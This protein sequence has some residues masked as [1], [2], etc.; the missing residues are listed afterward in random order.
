MI[1]EDGNLRVEKFANLVGSFGNNAYLVSDEVSREA[2]IVDAPAGS[3]VVLAAV[4][5]GGYVVKAVLLTHSHRDHWMGYEDVKAGTRAPFL[6]HEAERGVLGDR[7]DA[8]VS[9]RQDISVGEFAVHAIHTPGHTPGSTC[10]LVNGIVFSGDTLFP[11]GPGKTQTPS[12]LLQTIESI[13]ARLFVLPDET[14]VLPGHGDDTT[15]GS[16]KAEY[17]VFA[18]REHPA[19]LCGDVSWADS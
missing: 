10:Y 2:I 8:P 19:D 7:I 17:A 3:D 1:R 5:D 18:A 4:R 13:K 12:D 11:G 15:I 16:A 6:A 9:D 14:E